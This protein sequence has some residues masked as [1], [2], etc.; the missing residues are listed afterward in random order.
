M[1]VQ[2]ESYKFP[3]VLMT[4]SA[5]FYEKPITEHGAKHCDHVR[6]SLQ[7]S[8]ENKIENAS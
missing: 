5:N 7:T 8:P 6:V 1:A 4:M 3:C 2:Y